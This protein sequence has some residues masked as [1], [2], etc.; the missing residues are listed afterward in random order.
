MNQPRCQNA[1]TLIEMLTVIAIIAILAG[2]LFP[3][4]RGAITKGKVA[5]ASA[6]VRAIEAAIRQY[7]TEYGK[8]TS[9]RCGP[10]GFR[11]ILWTIQRNRQN[12]RHH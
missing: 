4:I 2:L 3:A 5:Q 9:S 8:I 6:D 1:F 10:R 11:Q 12:A 7:Y